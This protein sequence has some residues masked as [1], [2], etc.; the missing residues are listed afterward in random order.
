MVLVYFITIFLFFTLQ[1]L[2]LSDFSFASNVDNTMIL[3][4]NNQGFDQEISNTI[5]DNEYDDC[6]NIQYSDENNKSNSKAR[7]ETEIK[8]L[9]PEVR[10]KKFEEEGYHLARDIYWGEYDLSSDRFV[11][12]GLI[13]RFQLLEKTE[14]SKPKPIP[15]C[16]IRLTINSTYS[17]FTNY[18]IKY[19]NHNGSVVFIFNKPLRDTDWG[20]TLAKT[21]PEELIIYVEFSGNE[22]YKP[23]KT[24]PIS[25]THWP[26]AEMPPPPPPEDNSDLICLVS[27]GGVMIILISMVLFLF[28]LPED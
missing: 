20:Y 23:S 5:P 10:N 28:L 14:N 8:I 6:K 25:T 11:E 17:V 7:M 1:I 18:S 9:I 27:A 2:D 19:T 16:K 22:S 12:P 13:F 4:S 24:L 26:A 21:D 3:L 15:H